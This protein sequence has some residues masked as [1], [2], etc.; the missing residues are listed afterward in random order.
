[1][2]IYKPR[3]CAESSK[4]KERNELDAIVVMLVGDDSHNLD[5]FQR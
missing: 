3:C 4:K 5:S 1:M 2:L